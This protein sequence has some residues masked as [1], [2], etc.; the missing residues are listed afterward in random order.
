MTIKNYKP[1][2]M[3]LELIQIVCVKHGECSVNL[4]ITFMSGFFFTQI[5]LYLCQSRLESASGIPAL[6]LSDRGR[7]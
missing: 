4:I 7:I 1:D 2:K 5:Y 3:S 6:T